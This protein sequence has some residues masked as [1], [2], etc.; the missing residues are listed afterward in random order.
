VTPLQHKRQYCR[1][2]SNI[3]RCQGKLVTAIQHRDNIVELIATLQ[4]VRVG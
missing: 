1:T 4:D 2:D 3:T